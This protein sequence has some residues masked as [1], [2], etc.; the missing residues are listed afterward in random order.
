MAYAT[1]RPYRDTADVDND[2]LDI[3]LKV[4]D[5]SCCSY[6][7]GKTRY[8]GQCSIGVT[9]GWYE[10]VADMV[11]N[12]MTEQQIIEFMTRDAA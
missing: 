7:I 2:I 1:L 9:W 5:L 4:H 3:T 10:L 12:G 11:S 8:G 6:V